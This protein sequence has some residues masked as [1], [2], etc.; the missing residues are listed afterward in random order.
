MLGPADGL[1]QVDRA[2]HIG[3]ERFDRRFV[4]GPDDRQRRQVEYIVR[5]VTPDHALESGQVGNIT[6]HVSEEIAHLCNLEEARF[7]GWL[8]SH[9]PQRRHP[10][11]WSH[12]DSQDPLKSCMPREQNGRTI[13]GTPK[14]YPNHGVFP[15]SQ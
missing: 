9:T 4:G 15:S 5:L 6:A 3:G 1:E 8:E 7:G 11:R 2:H 14:A 12:N 10:R 13:E